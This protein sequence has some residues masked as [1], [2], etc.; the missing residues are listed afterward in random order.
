MRAIKT[1]KFFRKSMAA[2]L[3]IKV[4]DGHLVFPDKM[5]DDEIAEIVGR[6]ESEEKL[7]DQFS[8]KMYTPSEADKAIVSKIVRGQ[9]G[10]T[11]DLDKFG[12][13]EIIASNTLVDLYRERNTRALLDELAPQYKAQGENPGKTLLIN[14][15]INSFAGATFDAAVM[16]IA[17]KLDQSELVVRVYVP[18]FIQFQGNQV[19][20]LVNTGVISK[21]SMGYRP[22]Q[23][24]YEEVGDMVIGILDTDPTGN[25]KSVALEL[26]LAYQGAVLDSRVKTPGTPKPAFVNVNS[27]MSLQSKNFTIGKEKASKAFTIEYGGGDTPTLKGVEELVAHANSLAEEVASLKKAEADNKKP[28]IEGITALEKKL[29]YPETPESLLMGLDYKALSDRLKFYEEVDKK[30]NPKGQATD[31]DGSGKESTKTPETDPN[32]GERKKTFWGDED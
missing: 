13:F 20:D 25:R 2:E 29:K 24:K 27:D 30:A 17:G 3:G 4:K 12:F 19:L 7:A 1:P 18:D 6:L 10:K 15:G 21:A 11:Y 16:P 32:G 28:L 22:G 9:G 8:L 26:S 23:W 31:P 5:T 14:H